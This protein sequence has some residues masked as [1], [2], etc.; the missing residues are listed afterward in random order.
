MAMPTRPAYD[1]RPTEGGC[2]G[3]VQAVG[4]GEGHTDAAI[5]GRNH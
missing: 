2:Q 4:G 1:G 5:D 3:G